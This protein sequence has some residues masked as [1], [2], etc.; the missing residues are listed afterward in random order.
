MLARM[1]RSTV[2]HVARDFSIRTA[3]YIR[4]LAHT[5]RSRV[6]HVARRWISSNDVLYPLRGIALNG[7]HR[8]HLAFL[9]EGDAEMDLEQ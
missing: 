8:D 2:V 6:V 4:L 1:L 9:T 5:L 3:S 7:K